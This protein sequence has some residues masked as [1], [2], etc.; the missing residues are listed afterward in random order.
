MAKIKTCGKYYIIK[1]LSDFSALESI[2]RV[3]LELNVHLTSD[4]HGQCT[5][6]DAANLKFT[7]ILFLTRNKSCSN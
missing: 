7:P 6:D 5:S 3:P 4:Q 2:E 1:E